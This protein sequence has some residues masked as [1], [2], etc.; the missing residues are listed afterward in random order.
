[1]ILRFHKAAK[2][3]KLKVTYEKYI[4]PD[5]SNV[6]VLKPLDKLPL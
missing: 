2:T 4:N 5:R 6:A 3:G 1:M